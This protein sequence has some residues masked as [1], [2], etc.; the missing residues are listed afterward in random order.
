MN[1]ES[2]INTVEFYVES[3]FIRFGLMSWSVNDVYDA[4]NDSPHFGNRKLILEY[5]ILV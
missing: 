3:N 5:Q 1:L 4:I 2:K